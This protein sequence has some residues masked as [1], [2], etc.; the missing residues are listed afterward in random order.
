MNITDIKMRKKDHGRLKAVVSLTIDGNYALNDF[1]VIQGNKRLYV[2]FPRTKDG[3]NFFVPINN[4]AR[5]Y[6]ENKIL[7][8]YQTA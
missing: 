4:Q 7:Q 2:Q 8:A 1:Y 6:L 3:R 5:E